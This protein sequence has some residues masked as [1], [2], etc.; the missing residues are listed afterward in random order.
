MLA[1]YPVSEEGGPEERAKIAWVCRVKQLAEAQPV[2]AYSPDRQSE[3]TLKLLAFTNHETDVAKVPGLCLEYGVHFLYVPNLP[4][5]Y[6]DGAAL[7]VEGHPVIAVS[8]RYDRLDYFWF[9]VLHELAHIF[10]QTD[11]V[12]LDQLFNQA[13]P[14]VQQDEVQASQLAVQWLVPQEELKGFIEWNHPRYSRLEVT[15]FAE[16]QN[17]H[18]GII[19]GQLMY[20]GE[21]KFS[22]LREYL[23]KVR[24]YLE[25]WED[26]SYP[27]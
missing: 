7:W 18:P 1:S 9:T 3:F 27:G 11:E 2:Q 15:K 26:I 22:N 4:K 12:H 10:D 25:G 8:V 14:E 23:V 20:R 17:R 13:E 6:L 21:M 16:K 24:P 5:S 19:V